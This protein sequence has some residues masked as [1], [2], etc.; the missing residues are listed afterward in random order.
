MV[1]PMLTRMAAIVLE[2]DQ[3]YDDLKRGGKE[4]EDAYASTVILKSLSFYSNPKD[5]LENLFRIVW[6]DKNFS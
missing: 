3:V 4:I 6:S 2:Q 1:T 5:D